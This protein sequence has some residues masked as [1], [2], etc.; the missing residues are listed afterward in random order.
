MSVEDY[1]GNYWDTIHP[2][3]LGTPL[4]RLRSRR[5]KPCADPGCLW[6]V[7]IV[8]DPEARSWSIVHDCDGDWSGP[9]T[10]FVTELRVRCADCGEPFRFIG[11]PM[12]A[13]PRAPMVSVDHQE[14]RLPMAPASAPADFGLEG[15][16]FTITPGSPRSN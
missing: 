5:S 14:A 1:Q 10:A 3:G 15:P 6:T 8:Y 7:E 16:G 2:R 12:G 11:F 13:S 4:G 9:V